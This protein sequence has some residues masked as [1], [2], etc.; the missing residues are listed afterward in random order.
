MISV[1]VPE[2]LVSALIGKQG[3]IVKEISNMTG[4]KLMIREVEHD[5][6]QK[7]VQITGPAIGIAAAYIRVVARVYEADAKLAH[8]M[9]AA[10]GALGGQGGY[11]EYQ[12]QEYQ[13]QE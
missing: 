11:E 6:S 1:G 8:E 3:V 5:P 12:Q 2:N 9:A 10:G 13:Q 7:I 4:T